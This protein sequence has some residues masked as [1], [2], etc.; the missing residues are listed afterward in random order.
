MYWMH[1]F[2]GLDGFILCVGCIHAIRCTRTIPLLHVSIACVRCIHSMDW[3]R[4][5][6]WL[7]AFIPMIEC[8]HSMCWAH[9]ILLVWLL[10]FHVLG[11]SILCVGFIHPMHWVHSSIYVMHSFHCGLNAFVPLVGCISLHWLSAFLLWIAS[12]HSFVECIHSM[13][14]SHREHFTCFSIV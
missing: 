14:W 1:S 6:H 11:A 7:D 13:G 4:A 5:F 10:P 12:I 2:Y 8:M 3:M 9:S